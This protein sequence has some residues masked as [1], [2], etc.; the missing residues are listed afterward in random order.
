MKTK[1][2]FL[3]II[4][5]NLSLLSQSGWQVLNTFTS[6]DLSH[7]CFVNQNTGIITSYS[8]NIYRTSNGGLNWSQYVYTNPNVWF[9][10]IHFSNESTG[11]VIGYNLNSP[12]NNVILSTT[13]SGINWAEQYTGTGQ[14]REIYFINSQTG[15]VSGDSFYKTTNAGN[16]WIASNPQGYGSGLGIFF[17]DQLT[18]WV[19]GNSN[20]NN[21][22]IKTTNGGIN[23][24]TQL[25]NIS[26]MYSIKFTSLSTG[27][28]AGLDGIRKTTNNGTN[29]TICYSCNHA[30]S[31]SFPGIET[32][33]AVIHNSNPNSRKIIKTTDSGISWQLQDITDSRLLNFVYMLNANTGWVVGD[34][35]LIYKTTNGGVTGIHLV[36]NEI[37]SEFSLSQNYPN[38]FNP[39]TKIRF[40]VP[41]SGKIKFAIYDILGKEIQSINENN[42]S[43][44]SYEYSFDGTDLPSGI[45][46]YRLSSGNFTDT[47]KMVLIK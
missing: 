30:I 8:P 34:E 26:A 4:L 38:P 13:N 37:P 3:S 39:V 41:A 19:G 2:I 35:G 27:Y 21:S 24:A 7:V 40:D 14:M 43:T 31:L 22:V 9:W 33:W 23:W 46:F 16:N 42:L 32:G 6:N 28:C 36:S 20:N 12:Y 5:I 25:S 44:G 10:G 47:R 11:W 17:W 45:Y 1:F 15:F 29:W 18:G